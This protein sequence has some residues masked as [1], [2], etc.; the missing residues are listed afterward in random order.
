MLLVHPRT[1]GASATEHAAIIHWK[2]L[3]HEASGKPFRSA[4]ELQAELEWAAQA[5]T[6]DGSPARIQFALRRMTRA[7]P[8]TIGMSTSA[9]GRNRMR[10]HGPRCNM[11]LTNGGSP[12]PEGLCVCRARAADT[13]R[14]STADN[15]SHGPN[16]IGVLKGGIDS[17]LRWRSVTLCTP[18][19]TLIL[20]KLQS[21]IDGL[22]CNAA[23]PPSFCCCS[24]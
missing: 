1:F 24:A 14:N 13:S 8:A 10:R 9:V 2:R 6:G 21:Q 11:S 7:R 5:L 4:A 15:C 17:S 18:T 16:S 12:N 19:L 23:L 20:P 22:R 3:M